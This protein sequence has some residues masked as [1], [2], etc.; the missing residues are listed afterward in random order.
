MASSGVRNAT[1]Q[2]NGQHCGHANG[3]QGHQNPIS[4]GTIVRSTCQTWLGRLA[5]TV[6]PKG[7]GFWD[8]GDGGRTGFS[9]RIDVEL[10]KNCATSIQKGTNPCFWSVYAG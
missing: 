1:D 5:L 8:C 4:V 6:R 3:D 2:Q 7:L 9:L 10:P